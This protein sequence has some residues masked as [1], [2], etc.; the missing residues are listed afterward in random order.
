M[1][2]TEMMRLPAEEEAELIRA[3]VEKAKEFDR[4]LHDISVCHALECLGLDRPYAEALV[5]RLIDAGT[6]RRL[7]LPEPTPKPQHRA[8][9]DAPH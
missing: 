4:E 7:F 5:E 3:A 8:G 1:H 2:M 6:V 9:T